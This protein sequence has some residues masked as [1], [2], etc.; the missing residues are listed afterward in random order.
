MKKAI[1]STCTLISSCFFE[2]E[3]C[4][5]SVLAC[6]HSGV[7]GYLNG[8]NGR[9]VKMRSGSACRLRLTSLVMCEARTLSALSVEDR[10]QD[11]GAGLDERG[12]YFVFT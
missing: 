6:V 11:D 3:G 4:T 8:R 2:K 1:R 9:P 10:Q 5:G 7:S 12:R